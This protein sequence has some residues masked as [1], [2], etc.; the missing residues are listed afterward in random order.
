[1]FG[2]RTIFAICI[3]VLALVALGVSGYLTW[4]TWQA[5]SVA[6]CTAE[7]SFDCDSVLASR[8][9]KWLGLPV[10]LL[11]MMTY[12]AIVGLVWPAASRPNSLP[13]TAL[14]AASLLAAGAASWFVG[15]QVIQLQSFC[16]YC[17]TAHCCGLLTCVFALLMF[18]DTRQATNFEQMRSML[19]VATEAYVVE[20]VEMPE[21]VSVGRLVGALAVAGVGLMILMGGQLLFDTGEAMAM[22]DVE[23][24]P[25]EG[26]TDDAEFVYAD[27]GGDVAADDVATNIVAGDEVVGGVDV[28]DADTANVVSIDIDEG[29]SVPSINQQLIDREA[30]PNDSGEWGID[31]IISSAEPNSIE[32]L[33]NDSAISEPETIASVLGSTGPRRAVFKALPEGVDV[34]NMPVIGNPNAPHVLLEMMDYTCKHCRKLHPHLVA[35]VDRY[36]DQL[37]VVIYN[38]PLS[39]KCNF[40]VKRDYPGKKYACDYAHLSLAVWKLAPQHYLDFHQW[41]LLD[42]EKAPSISKVKR[43]ARELAGN[44]VLLDKDIRADNTRRIN[45]QVKAFSRLNS[46][47]PVLLLQ[48][49]ALR[50][51]PDESEKLFEYLESKLDLQPL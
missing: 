21:P 19:G 27:T 49:S 31:D 36:G 50:G 13:V 46:G 34:R 37:A 39:K 4:V 7:S 1:M 45:T 5:D 10:S 3:T 22:Q 51:V 2:R 23:F 48:D 9:S 38:V 15:L 44:Q 41:L 32:A 16:L 26:S 20:E 40:K 6:G 35:A 24:V 42:E 18:L 33:T 11:G 28:D 17:L 47:L 8:W 12:A 29:E 43:R 30:S 14:L 25:I